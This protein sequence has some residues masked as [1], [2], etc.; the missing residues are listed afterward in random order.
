M[1]FSFFFQLQYKFL[2]GSDSWN[3]RIIGG[4]KK[5]NFYLRGF[6]YLFIIRK[7]VPNANKKV[8]TKVKW[9]KYK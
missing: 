9:S 3:Y 6:K 8:A 1:E 5:F 4:F 7:P 2:E